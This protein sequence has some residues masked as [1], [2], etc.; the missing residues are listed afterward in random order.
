MTYRFCS[1]GFPGGY[2]PLVCVCGGYLPLSILRFAQAVAHRFPATY[3][4]MA[5]ADRF[6]FGGSTHR[7]YSICIYICMYSIYTSA[8]LGGCPPLFSAVSDRFCRIGGRLPLL[9]YICP[10]A[11]SR[12]LPT[13]FVLAVVHRFRLGG[14]PPLSSW[15][16]PTAF[17]S[18]VTHRY[19]ATYSLWRLPT[20]RLYVYL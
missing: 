20:A 14:S 4:Y 6:P 10:P 13:A 7:F 18:A 5:V 9:C 2:Q 3:I 15:R 8:F 1:G 16:F 12:R 17:T 19:P 11:S